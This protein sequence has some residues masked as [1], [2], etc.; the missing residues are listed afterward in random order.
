M[1]VRTV[2]LLAPEGLWSRA[3]RQ[4]CGL[5]SG[6]GGFESRMAHQDDGAASAELP[7][8]KRVRSGWQ[9]HRPSQALLARPG[10]AI[11]PPHLTS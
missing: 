8:G 7:E 11:P 4:A 6:D 3:S 9:P 10:T 1:T 5:P 2:V